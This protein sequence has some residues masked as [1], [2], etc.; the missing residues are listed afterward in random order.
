MY[1]TRIALIRSLATAALWG[2]GCSSGAPATDLAPQP[3]GDMGTPVV[4]GTPQLS[5][6]TPP[7][8]FSV[9]GVA[10]T[11]T[12]QEFQ[13]GALVTFDGVP[14]TQV[15]VT[16]KTQIF[17]MLPARLGAFGLVPVV[18]QNLS[19]LSATRGDLFSYYATQ[20]AFGPGTSFNY[21]GTSQDRSV[22]LGDLNGDQKLDLVT[23][24]GTSDSITIMLGDGMGG[25][26]TPMTLPSTRYVTGVAIVDLNGDKKLD[27]VALGGSDN[28]LSLFLGDGSGGFAPRKDI[29]TASFGRKMVTADFNGDQKVDVLVMTGSSFYIQLGDGLGGFAAPVYNSGSGDS[30]AVGDWNGD[31]NLDLAFSST[32]NAYISL[33]L[34]NGKGVFTAGQMV[35]SLAAANALTVLDYDGDGKLDLAVAFKD[36]ASLLHGDG[37]AHFDYGPTLGSGYSSCQAITVADFDGDQKL[38]IAILSG[39]IIQILSGDGKGTFSPTANASGPFSLDTLIAADFNKDKKPDILVASSSYGGFSLILNQSR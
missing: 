39:S 13:Q 7:I 10:M 3:I 5:T 8:G 6:V 28:K 26:A 9:G 29:A 30:V 37:T 35:Y 33:Y 34:N 23:A 11:L 31:K 38:D 21:S 25:F 12:G 15:S 2:L 1:L 36:K 19:G 20:L 14:A 24:N 18:V 22:A 32:S 4:P 27:I 17:A 16:S